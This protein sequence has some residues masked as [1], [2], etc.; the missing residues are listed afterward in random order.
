MGKNKY[1]LPLILSLMIAFLIGCASTGIGTKDNNT[2][3]TGDENPNENTE[4]I[5]NVSIRMSTFILGIGDTVEISVYRQDDLKRTVRI[6]HSGIITLPLIG[7]VQAAGKDIF[8]LREEIKERLSKY[9]IDPQVTVNVTTV[10]SQKIIVLGEVNSP[11]IFTLEYDINVV[12][13][14][15]RAGG[16]TNDAKLNNVLLIRREQ[17]KPTVISLNLKKAFKEGDI[18]QNVSLMNG[19]I[20]YLPAVTIANVSRY[21]SHISQIVSPF[22][23]LESGIVLWP[24]V[25]KVLQGKETGEVPLSIPT[26]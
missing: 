19:D 11:G 8:K 7:D 24:Q 16:M 13:A 3:K 4:K 25:K 9:M 20:I 21:F 10:Q 22:V 18:S 26:R 17:G 12:E 15:S 23:N 2:K 1:K 5:D 14:I 6:G